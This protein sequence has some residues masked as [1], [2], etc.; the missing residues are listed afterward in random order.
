MNP[1]T[2]ITS[3]KHEFYFNNFQYSPLTLCLIR[4]GLCNLFIFAFYGVITISKK[5]MV[6]NLHLILWKN[7]NLILLFRIWIKGPR[8]RNNS[9]GMPFIKKFKMVLVLFFSLD[10]ALVFGK[11]TFYPF[12]FSIERF[13]SKPF[14]LF[15]SS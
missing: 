11:V 13:G 10:F 7:N 5:K 1:K 3:K 8:L 14:F 15:F 12:Y 9:N 4:T 2:Q 6:L